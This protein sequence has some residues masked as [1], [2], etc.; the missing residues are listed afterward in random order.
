MCSWHSQVPGWSG[1]MLGE[2]E[3]KAD[4]RRQGESKEPGQEKKKR[5]MIWGTR[6][7]LGVLKAKRSKVQCRKGEEDYQDAHGQEEDIGTDTR[8]ERRQ[9]QVGR[10]NAHVG[11]SACHGCFPDIQG[12][13]EPWTIPHCY[14]ME[15][16]DPCP[17]VAWDVGGGT[18]LHASSVSIME[19][20]RE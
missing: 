8:P 18:C 11:R 10:A 20:S 1:Y 3:G 7:A 12:P 14:P 2:G 13:P 4:D 19:S 16:D 15:Y 9:V 6:M 5:Q 17:C